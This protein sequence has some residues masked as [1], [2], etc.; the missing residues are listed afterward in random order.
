[1]YTS[2][3]L[4]QKLK[5]YPICAFNGRRIQNLF[6]MNFNN[7]TIKCREAL[8]KATEIATTRGQQVIETGHLLQAIFQSDENLVSFLF[9]KIGANQSTIEQKLD[10]II[11][12]YPLVSGGQAYLSNR[13][14]QALQNAEAYLKD[15]EDEYVA[16][17]HIILGI[18][19]GEDQTAQLLKDSEFDQ[20][21]I[22]AAIVE[23]RGGQ[24]ARDVHAESKYRVLDRYAI[25]LNKLAL[26]GKIDPVIGR[27]EEIR[28]V[29]QILA[30][31]SKN[32]PILL[33]EPGVGKTAIVEGLAQRIVSGDIP[34]N[35]K[36]KVIVS[37]DMGL[38]IAGAKFKGE[39]EERLKAVIKEVTD[40]DGEIILFI[41][42]IHVLI[43]TGGG[44]DGAIDAANLLKPALARGELH[45][46]GATTLNEYQKY[47]EKDKALERRFQSVQVAEPNLQDAISILRGIKDKYELHHGVQIKDEAI[48]L[49]VEL[50]NRYITDRF[51]PDKAIDL[52]DEAA[53]KLRIEIDSLPAELDEQNRKIR[54]LEIEQEAIRRE[55]D[56][57]KALDLSRTISD[58][59]ETRNELKAKWENEKGIIHGIRKQKEAIESLKIQADQ[60]ERI[61][62][63][64][65][66]AEIR[67]GK[68]IEAEK[69]LKS[70]QTQLLEMQK[71]NFL[72]KEEVDGADI[73][74]VVAKW[75]GVPLAK[76]LQSE[77]VK[78]LG[79]E[80]EL[81]KKIA[82]QSEAIVAVADAVRRGRSGLQDPKRPIGSFMFLGTTGIGKTELAKALAD[83]LFDDQNSMVRIDLSEY[84]ESHAVSRLI[85]AP[86]G[87]I[88]YDEGGQLTEAVRR[89]PYSVILLDEI[90]KA[91]SDV[92]NIL[93]QVLDDG[94]LTD[95]KGR[96][97]NFKNT[98]II[99]TTNLG[100]HLIQE[101]LE[102][103]EEWNFEEIIADTEKQ[104]LDLA[105]ESFRP[106]FLNR[107]DEIIMFR[108]LTKE[109]LR[110]IVG[111]QFKLIQKRLQE[112]GIKI[113]ADEKV[114]L[115][116][117]EMGFDPQLGARPLKRTLQNALLNSL[118]KEILQGNLNKEAI[119]GV[120]LDED[121]N[122]EFINLDDVSV[123]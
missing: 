84:Q 38:L 28:R 37:L 34:E 49:A 69:K 88:G 39:F 90:E 81:G 14:A 48:I 72:L 86:P 58:L 50:S 55:N 13:A 57:V 89:K 2:V 120:T 79:L 30:R 21:S 52:I 51:L 107:V 112:N 62:E 3:K 46:I 82:G 70:Y 29:L 121:Q 1:M 64:G 66:V 15:L 36:S 99:M 68:I 45:A 47:I 106:E 113:E 11:H 9:K 43:G 110:Q 87:Y 41:D 5:W 32:N 101:N 80:E 56:Q 60:M 104:V 94:I 76:M 105:T 96:T 22:L 7:Y 63:L 92:F 122:I 111:I 93:L 23:L 61:G 71:G 20:K 18:L 77:R 27:D 109:N 91:H 8:N 4:T 73:S 100:G 108:P 75:T 40:S 10:E 119:I 16:V 67:Y 44:N 123:N 33:G 26:K 83:Y 115:Y 102:R 116:L 98:I 42:E 65:H 85:G 25:N 17:E 19:K 54:Q 53:S 24:K 74:E 59:E 35:L 31:R 97:A 78:L 114:L 103:L 6:N 95:N 118:S 12:K 117:A